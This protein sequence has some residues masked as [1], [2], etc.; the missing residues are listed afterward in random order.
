MTRT[1]L[2]LLTLLILTFSLASPTQAQPE[3]PPDTTKDG[4]ERV[5]DSQVALLYVQPGATLAPYTRVALIDPQVSFVAGYKNRMNARLH[6]TAR[7]TD[8]DMEDMQAALAQLFREVFTNELQNNGG[9]VL[10]DGAAD[11]VLA[12]RP[13]IIDLDVL[14]PELSPNQRSTVP[15]VGEMT[16]YL[17]LADSITGNILA[18]V[19]DHQFDRTRVTTALRNRDRNERAFRAMLEHWAVLMR[20]SLDEAHRVTAAD[21]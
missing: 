1:A 9:Y 10:V 8:A 2:N 12:L 20:E 7:V 17:E 16:L 11:D 14:G 13:A 4:L 21:S 3:E 5:P 6:N 18:K 15:S 19:L